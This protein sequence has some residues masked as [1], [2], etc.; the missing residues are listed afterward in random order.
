MARKDRKD[1]K[2]TSKTWRDTPKGYPWERGESSFN[3]EIRPLVN[4]LQS[5]ADK[6]LFNQIKNYIIIRL[7]SILEDFFKTLVINMVD[8]YDLPLNVLWNDEAK[9]P[10]S[11]LNEMLSKKNLGMMMKGKIVA[12]EFNFA[13]A[14]KVNYVFT[15]LL[16]TNEKFKEVNKE[17]FDAIKKHVWH[18]PYRNF[19]GTRSLEKNWRNF[20]R[21]FDERNKIVH[22]M[23]TTDLSVKEIIS[24]C[25]NTLNAM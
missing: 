12:N 2:I 22:N 10:I 7:V 11:I 17:F 6:S 14:K 21:M 18:D 19:K 24:L 5:S 8:N 15:E 13:D 4:Y 25:D 23:K 16:N 3:K 1:L 9:V 20:E